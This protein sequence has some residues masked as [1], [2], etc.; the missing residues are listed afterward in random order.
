M[1]RLQLA[2]PCLDLCLFTNN[3][4]RLVPFWQDTMGLAAEDSLQIREGL[5]QYR[6]NTANSVVKLN[7]YDKPVEP[8][9]IGGFREL[10]IARNELLEPHRYG[11][12][13]GNLVSL[14]PM[15]YLHATQIAVRTVV[16]NLS[17]AARFYDNVLGLEVSAGS[18]EGRVA[19]G[20][21]VLLLYED[22]SANLNPPVHA[23][24][25]RFITLQIF[26]ANGLYQQVIA[27][28]GASGQAPKT[29]GNIARY[30]LVRDPD[31]NWVELSQ[32]ASLT[33][34]IDGAG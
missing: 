12:P 9:P 25:W 32:R 31:G 27:R 16:R 24:G 18:G 30:A 34:P 26:D 8:G 17:A 20:E 6:F 21:S 28:G 33:G 14:V 4:A 22:S 23:P 13:D 19:I 5:T 10:L 29:V 7:A 2:K 11:D 15:G 3:A 1:A